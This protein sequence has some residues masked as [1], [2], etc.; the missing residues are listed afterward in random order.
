MERLEVRSLIDGQLLHIIIR[1]QRISD[2]D[3]FR[4]LEIIEPDNFLQ[5]AQLFIPKGF[6]FRAHSHLR[7]ERQFANLIAQES[8]VVMDGLVHVRYFDLDDKVLMETELRPGDCSVTLEGGHEY[9][10]TDQSARVFEFKSG[11][12]EGVEIDKRFI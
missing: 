9:W 8:W 4:R 7:R 11:P 5:A 1:S 10:T 12:Y 2:Q 3:A 6:P